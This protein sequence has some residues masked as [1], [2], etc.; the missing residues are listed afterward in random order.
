MMSKFPP[1]VYPDLDFANLYVS[2]LGL[3][4]SCVSLLAP[5]PGAEPGTLRLAPEGSQNRRR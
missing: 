5:W 3:R 2:S 1:L 4:V